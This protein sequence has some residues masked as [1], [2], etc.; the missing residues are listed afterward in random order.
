MRWTF[1]EL[2]ENEN[3]AGWLKEKREG[4]G[5]D[6]RLTPLTEI[7]GAGELLPL[8]RDLVRHHTKPAAPSPQVFEGP[9]AYEELAG[10]IVGSGM[11]PLAYGQQLVI[12]SGLSPKGNAAATLKISFTPSTYC[13]CGIA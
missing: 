1:V 13:R 4:A 3:C 5:R 12:Q 11:E 9:S 2:V 10:A 8:F 7:T 6:K